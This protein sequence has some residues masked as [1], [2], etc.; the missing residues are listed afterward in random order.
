MWAAEPPLCPGA[1]GSQVSTVAVTTTSVIA[2]DE[3]YQCTYLSAYSVIT[4]ALQWRRQYHFA[5]QAEV[6]GGNVYIAHDAPNVDL[7]MDDIVATTGKVRW[8]EP[9]DAD[10][11]AQFAFSVGSGLVADDIWVASAATGAT[12]FTLDLK[13]AGTTAGTTDIRGGR[14]VY[15]SFHAVQAY[16]PTDGHLLWAHGSN[17]YPAPG[18]GFPALDGGELYYPGAYGTVVL[19]ASTGQRGVTLP[20]T[21]ALAVDGPIGIFTAGTSQDSQAGTVTARRLSDGHPLWK[22]TLPPANGHN[23][24]ATAPL[25]ANGLVWFSSG[26][27]SGTP[28]RLIGLDEVTGAIRTD[29]PLTCAPSYGLTVAQ[30]HI[31]VPTECGIQV[32]G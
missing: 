17:A 9:I 4:G 5:R 11:N 13:P 7:E 2:L 24:G 6:V 32:F 16:S 29:L 22:T 26:Y 10:A 23:S 25:I 31:V 28:G 27:D 8:S 1:G 30:H 3:Q 19:N 14:V 21:N 15:N 12:K 20:P 18:G